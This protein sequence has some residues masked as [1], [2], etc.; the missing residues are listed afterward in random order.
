MPKY[1]FVVTSTISNHRFKSLMQIWKNFCE[2]CHNLISGIYKTS[3]KTGDG[4]EEMFADIAR[5]LSMSNRSRMELQTI[6]ETS[7]QVARG[8]C[9]NSRPDQSQGGDGCSC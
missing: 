8:G 2:Q 5:Q 4:V 3:C 9:S 1:S 7:F 6:E